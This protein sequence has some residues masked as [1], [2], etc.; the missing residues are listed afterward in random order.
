MASTLI[1]GRGKDRVTDKGHGT[2]ALGP[3]DTSDSASDIVGGPGTVEGDVIGLD[4]GTNED[5]E[6]RG[7]GATAG[8]DIGD[9]ELD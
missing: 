3:S 7:G 9:A 4:S 8:V 1:G 2:D 5:P 6:V